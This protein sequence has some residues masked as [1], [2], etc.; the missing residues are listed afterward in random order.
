MPAADRVSSDPTDTARSQAIP[1][2]SPNG[3][4]N[5]A[6]QPAVAAPAVPGHF[7]VRT[8]SSQVTRMHFF[9]KKSSRL[10]LIVALKTQRPP[11]LP[12]LFHCQNK[13]N[14]AVRYGRIFIFCS[15]YY[16]SKATG[17]AGARAVDL[18]VRSFD[19]AR[20]GIAPPLAAS[21][22]SLAP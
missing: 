1:V 17:R 7:E 19:L 14:K 9:L 5:D 2:T 16:Q 8:S 21:A 15:H 22:T 20:P 3:T 6:E 4:L 13:T 12:R 11:M 18:P 10:F